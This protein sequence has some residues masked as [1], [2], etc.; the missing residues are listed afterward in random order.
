MKITKTNL[1][2]LAQKTPDLDNQWKQ[3]T[4]APIIHLS[5]SQYF[6]KILFFISLLFFQNLLCDV[7]KQNESELTKFDL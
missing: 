7:I 1:P 6:G 5:C 2:F 4:Q 3:Q